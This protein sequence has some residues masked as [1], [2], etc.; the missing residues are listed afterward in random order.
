MTP[1]RLLLVARD[2]VDARQDRADLV[3]SLHEQRPAECRKGRGDQVAIRRCEHIGLQVEAEAP[4]GQRL[5][6]QLLAQ[7]GIDLERENAVIRDASTT[8]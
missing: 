3:H 6:R 1:P 5:L 4:P 8:K 2:R 7:R